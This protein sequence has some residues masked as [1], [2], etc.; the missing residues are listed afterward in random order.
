MILKN[1]KDNP[2]AKVNP[3]SLL[4]LTVENLHAMTHLK[5][6]T[7]LPVHCANDFGSHMLESAKKITRW[8]TYYFT[9]PSSYYPVPSSQIN[10]KDLPH[11][12]PLDNPSMTPEDKELMGKWAHEKRIRKCRVTGG[13]DE[14]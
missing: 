13:N 5:H 4:T 6:P 1:E 12:E 7:C 14:I 8:S 10:W 2:E 3:E 11:K 9:Q